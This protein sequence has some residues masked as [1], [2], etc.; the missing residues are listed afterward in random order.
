M[1]KIKIGIIGGGNMGE[2]IAVAVKKGFDVSV[3][4]ADA[5]KAAALKR[6]ASLKIAG[7]DKVLSSC[8]VIILAVK[9]QSFDGLLAVIKKA[10]TSPKLYISIAAGIKTSYIEK[11][12]GK[13]ARVVR[14][15]PNLPARVGAAMTGICAGK[16]AKATDVN[17]AKNVFSLVGGVVT[18]NEPQMDAVTAI[19]GSGPAYVYLFME[20][21]QQAARSIGFDEKTSRLLVY[22]TLAGS[23]KLY[24]N[25][26]EDAATLRHR[27]TSKGGTTEAAVKI[28]IKKNYTA[29]I[30]AAVKKAKQ[31]AGELSK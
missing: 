12:L 14:T 29:I 20:S 3:C 4:E 8:S 24:E 17:L 26:G 5:R 2:A 16:S 21:L 13:T 25:S 19:S 6:K 31:R 15:M 22:Q 18:V 7:L 1:K 11:R 30:K 27:V 10:R 9:P 28:F 23:L